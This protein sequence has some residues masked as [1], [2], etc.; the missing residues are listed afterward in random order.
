VWMEETMRIGILSDT[1]N[2]LARTVAA[3]ELLRTE[4]AEALIHCG[5]LT[6]SDVVKV[7]GVLPAYF[8]FGNNDADN[9]AALLRAIEVVSGVCLQWGGEV[10]LAGRRVAV[11]HGHMHTDVRRLLAAQ[12]DYLLSGHSHIASDSRIGPTRR[13][14][15]GA[16]HRATEFTVA[17]LD[18]ETDALRFFGVARGVGSARRL[19]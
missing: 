4:G 9:V 2:K 17:L 13:I 11:A 1:H 6:G 16:L 15:P 12:P 5:D 14:N 8:V 10:A 7:C 18:L 3:V 19:A